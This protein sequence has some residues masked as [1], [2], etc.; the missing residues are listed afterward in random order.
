[1]LGVTIRE[2]DLSDGESIEEIESLDRTAFAGD[3]PTLRIERGHWWLAHYGDIAVAYGG[4]VPARTHVGMA[5]F[6]RAG[7]LSEFRG[8]GLQCRLI[9]VREHH[10]RRHG[11]VGAVTD[12]K[13]NLPSANNLIRCGFK[14]FEPKHR[15]AFATSLYWKKDLSA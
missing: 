4:Y 7:V 8:C 2:V 15:W 9:R 14:L 12:T 11:Y 13:D 1:M 6:I 10:A 3:A 5:Y